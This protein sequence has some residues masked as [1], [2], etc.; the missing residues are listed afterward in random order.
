VTQPDRYV[1]NPIYLG[2][3]AVIAGGGLIASSLSIVALAFGF[4]AIAHLFV[5]LYEEP[6]LGREFGDSYLQYRAAVHRWLI[7]PPRKPRAIDP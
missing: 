3:A 1:R 5:V 7:R 2:A 4:L 6:A